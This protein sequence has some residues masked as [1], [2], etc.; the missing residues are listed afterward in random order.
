MRHR[1]L[2]NND[3]RDL[4][5]PCKWCVRV[6]WYSISPYNYLNNIFFCIL[7][8]SSGDYRI[9]CELR[10]FKKKIYYTCLSWFF[11]IM[12]T[13]L[14]F[15]PVSQL[16]IKCWIAPNKFNLNV[17]PSQCLFNSLTLKHCKPHAVD[18]TESLSLL[19]KLNWFLYLYCAI[20]WTDLM[21]V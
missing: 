5:I 19:N 7:R 12:C 14:V 6:L 21:T 16:Q 2:N 3:I 17:T 9:I 11:H 18:N 4:Y 20:S 15:W 10:S 1:N 8:G 13:R